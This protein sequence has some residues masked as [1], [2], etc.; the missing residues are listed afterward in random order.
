VPYFSLLAFSGLL[1]ATKAGLRGKQVEGIDAM[2]PLKAAQT[3]FAAAST[4]LTDK[5]LLT[6][7]DITTADADTT[8]HLYVATHCVTLAGPL[9]DHL[10]A[11]HASVALF[12]SR[13]KHWQFR[14]LKGVVSFK[15]YL[16]NRRLLEVFMQSTDP[17]NA[18]LPTPSI[19]QR[20]MR[21]MTTDQAIGALK[22]VIALLA[23]L[24]ILW[25]DETRTWFLNRNI[26]T[27]TV[28]LILAL[29]PTLGGSMIAWIAELF[30]T[31][32]GAVWGFVTMLVWR[33]RGGATYSV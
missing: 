6:L 27:A 12:S 13:P 16:P 11:V 26:Q 8:S 10:Q 9:A 31:F 2:T 1:T 32:S 29:M 24:S 18:F 21:M 3:S 7:S 14:V 5:M 19:A 20:V 4:S 17:K 15:T 22:I 30:G 25:A 23:M 28:P 33:N